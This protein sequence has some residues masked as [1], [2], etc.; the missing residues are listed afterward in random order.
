MNKMKKLSIIFSVAVL[1]FMVA[2]CN[3]FKSLY[4]KY[5]SNTQLPPDVIG[6]KTVDSIAPNSSAS[7]S[8]REFFTDPLLQK[9]IDSAL[10]QNTDLNSACIAVDKSEVSLQMAKKAILPTFYVSPSTSFSSFGSVTSQTYNLPLQASWDYGSIGSITNKKRAAKAVL[11]QAQAREDAVHAN[12][13]SA[14]AQQYCLLQ[15]LDRQLEILTL[16]DSLWNTS[17][18][19]QKALWEFGKGIFHCR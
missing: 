9:L 16:T 7:L 8:W 4:N 2:S 15:L 19:T 3:L 14:V 10:V 17:L 12:L 5:E 18:Q 13:V 6:V 1:G 11:M